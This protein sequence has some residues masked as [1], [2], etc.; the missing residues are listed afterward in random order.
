MNPETRTQPIRTDA[1]GSALVLI[2]LFIMLLTTMSTGMFIYAAKQSQ[3]ADSRYT[4]LASGYIADAGLEAATVTLLSADLILDKNGNGI[5]DKDDFPFTIPSAVTVGRKDETRDGK[6][7]FGSYTYAI[8]YAEAE[9]VEFEFRL[10]P[11]LPD[12]AAIVYSSAGTVNDIYNLIPF[13]ACS[14]RIRENN[15]VINDYT[16]SKDND[17]SAMTSDL[18]FNWTARNVM[19]PFS[20]HEYLLQFALVPLTTDMPTIDS[21][22]EPV[23][24][25]G[26]RIVLY[27]NNDGPNNSYHITDNCYPDIVSV[28][29]QSLGGRNYLS[30][31]GPGA[32]YAKYYLVDIENLDVSGQGSVEVRLYYTNGVETYQVIADSNWNSRPHAY[33]LLNFANDPAKIWESPSDASFSGIDPNR[34]DTQQIFAL[35][36]QGIPA[37][38]AGINISISRGFNLPVSLSYRM[39]TNY[40]ETIDPDCWYPEWPCDGSSSL[41]YETL[42]LTNNPNIYTDQ[43]L[44]NALQLLGRRQAL[45]VDQMYTVTS[46][47]N[48][49]NATESRQ[50][51]FS[52]ESFLDYS[53]FITNSLTINTSATYSGRIYCEDAMT[54]E[55]VN[56]SST[57]DKAKFYDDVIVARGNL[58]DGIL[59]GLEHAEFLANAKLYTRAEMQ[60]LPIREN[61]WSYYDYNDYT[62][63][64]LSPPSG[65]AYVFLGPYNYENEMDVTEFGLELSENTGPGTDDVAY[66]HGPDNLMSQSEWLHPDPSIS[67]PYT[68]FPN[69]TSITRYT[70][71]GRRFNGLVIVD[72]DLHIWGKLRGRSLTFVVDGD[73]YIEREIIMGTTELTDSN[74]MADTQLPVHLALISMKRDNSDG[75]IIISRNCPRVM[76]IESA[77][78]AIK[79]NWR[80]EDHDNTTMSLDDDDSH[81]FFLVNG[82][83]VTAI[84]EFWDMNPASI[85]PTDPLKVDMITTNAAIPFDINGDGR[86]SSSDPADPAFIELNGWNELDIRNQRVWYLQFVGPII[87]SDIG[88]AYAFGLRP[89]L[90]G[91]S[92]TSRIYKYDSTI[93]FNPPPFFPVPE[94]SIRKLEY[95]SAAIQLPR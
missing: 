12:P 73:I 51:L 36:V 69:S 82:N 24:W 38:G 50:L 25:F 74:N 15:E 67:M 78:V 87:T 72:G 5:V 10:Q 68:S 31:N 58:G 75:D 92:V 19:N 77:L 7:G 81:K 54:I 37:G 27:P 62:A 94:R 8:D 65:A 39:R 20:D 61:L 95:S 44:N 89:D 28:P 34:F 93:R 57:S 80:I 29:G 16:I 88:R 11:S 46:V 9:E 41:T 64:K 23:D 30:F 56:P 47:G 22:F 84:P 71:A 32:G 6:Q 76:R 83:T 45:R 21:R 66:Y 26:N 85:P 17:L 90:D 42:V 55:D 35:T 13:S 52:P 49:E 48:V 43:I 53:R 60:S 2:L 79:G 70:P 3:S 63:W 40:M 4:Q 91:S 18:T 33:A 59:N 1:H 14:I 86:L